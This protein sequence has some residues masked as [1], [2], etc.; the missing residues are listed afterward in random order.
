MG[1]VA[2]RYSVLPR[3]PL[4][5]VLWEG[6]DE[7]EPAFHFRFDAGVSRQVKSLD[8]LWAM[9]NVVSSC[10]ES[11]ARELTESTE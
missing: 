2:F 11:L 5:L 4:V 1:D 10:L 6:D 7:F 3:I 8:T 9:V